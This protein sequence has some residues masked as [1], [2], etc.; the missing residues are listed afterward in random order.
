[1]WETPEILGFLGAMT[2]SVPSAAL[3]EPGNKRGR[4]QKVGQKE[5]IYCSL[6][7]RSEVREVLGLR[8]SRLTRQANT[9]GLVGI[10]H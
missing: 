1:M 6:W 2:E 8:V 10:Q 5:V 4:S 9:K 3:T 7:T